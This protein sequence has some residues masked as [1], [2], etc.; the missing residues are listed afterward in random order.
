MPWAMTSFGHSQLSRGASFLPPGA[1]DSSWFQVLS[2][3][4]WDFSEIHLTYA[5]PGINRRLWPEGNKNMIPVKNRVDVGRLIRKARK[6]QG[7]SQ[8]DLAQ[9]LG[10]TQKWVSRVETGK[11]TTPQLDLVLLALR[12]LRVDLRAQLRSMSTSESIIHRIA[13]RKKSLSR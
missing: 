7:W 2:F 1:V 6:Q 12:L 10:S 4:A 13:G 9:K 11:A 8:A 3:H 5:H